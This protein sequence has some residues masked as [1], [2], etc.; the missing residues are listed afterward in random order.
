M[1]FSSDVLN[2]ARWLND[3][4]VLNGS[5]HK[6]ET[7]IQCRALMNGSSAPLKIVHPLSTAVRGRRDPRVSRYG[8]R[9]GGNGDSRA[10]R[11]RSEA[12][13]TA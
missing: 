5:F 4:N 7:N 9:L 12:E 10:V 8:D 2:G 13:E 6:E 1:A 3:L 11:P